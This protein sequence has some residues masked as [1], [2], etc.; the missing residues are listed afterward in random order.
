MLTNDNVDKD[1]VYWQ[2]LTT[3]APFSRSGLKPRQLWRKQPI[4]NPNQWWWRWHDDND[5]TNH[6]YDDDDGDD[7][8]DDDDASVCQAASPAS[9][10]RWG[11]DCLSTTAWSP[12]HFNIP[13]ITIIIVIVI[14][15][16][17][18]I[19][20][21]IFILITMPPCKKSSQPPKACSSAAATN[22]NFKSITTKM[23]RKNHN[24]WT[25]ILFVSFW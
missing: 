6:D 17:I 16:V 15:A 20:L 2:Q 23:K 9:L 19:S 8:D 7:E 10:L 25:R 4:R 14:V 22:V 12:T 21:F 11:L 24:F 3:V 1:D 5:T 18:I 13:F